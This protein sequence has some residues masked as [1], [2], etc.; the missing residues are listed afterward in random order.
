[1]PIVMPCALKLQNDGEYGPCGDA[2]TSGGD[3]GAQ[4]P[5]YPTA[6]VSRFAS[7]LSRCAGRHAMLRP[8]LV[9]W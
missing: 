4:V 9:C 3:I 8:T 6:W 7:E 5:I 2:E 1:M